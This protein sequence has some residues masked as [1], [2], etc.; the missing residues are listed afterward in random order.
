MDEDFLDE[1]RM[2]VPDGKVGVGLAGVFHV[3]IMYFL[4]L[5]PAKFICSSVYWATDF[6]DLKISNE[7]KWQLG[8]SL[9]PAAVPA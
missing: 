6:P 7:V 5:A 9:G 2:G 3:S 8:C 4:Q 1:P